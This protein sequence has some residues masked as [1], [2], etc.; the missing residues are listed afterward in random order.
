MNLSKIVQFKNLIDCL[1][2]DPVGFEAVRHFENMLYHASSDTE[3]RMESD[4]KNL[5]RDFESIQQSVESFRQSFSNVSKSLQQLIESQDQILY[6]HSMRVYQEE[7]SQDTVSTIL[8]RT[9]RIDQ[10][11]ENIM[12]TRIKQRG[13]WRIPGMIIRPGIE[14]YINDMVALDP[15]YLV[16][17][18]LELL[19]PATQ[20][21]LPEYQRR[22]RLY[23]INDYAEKPI[24]KK[25]PVN[26]FGLIF[27]YNYFNFKPLSVISNYLEEIFQL[28]RPGGVLMFTY[29][30]CDQWHCVAF[31]EKNQMCY[32][33]GNKLKKIAQ[34]HGY[35]VKF[36]YDGLSDAK[37]IELQKPGEITSVKGG[38]SMAKIVAGQ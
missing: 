23:T 29:N 31:A 38:Q 24:F 13:D 15:L 12:Q 33:P 25:F 16:D 30:N 21:Y 9:L 22:L 11:S 27:A 1:K 26:Q 19:E 20:R 2:P 36:E 14:S 32:T 10:T 4:I 28:L 8:N 18:D 5:E 3:L 37:W 17:R 35:I 34:E 7:F 6:S